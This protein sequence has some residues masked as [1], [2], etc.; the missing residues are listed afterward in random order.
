[1]Q[2]CMGLEACARSCHAQPTG[3][4]QKLKR[5]IEDGK[6]KMADST[7]DYGMVGARRTLAASTT[8]VAKRSCGSVDTL[9]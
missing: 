6:W 8:P 1:M 3:V 5:I 7:I 2:T 4:R 9:T